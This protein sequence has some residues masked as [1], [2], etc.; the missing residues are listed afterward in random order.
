M[1]PN[2]LILS[3]PGDY[4]LDLEG[5]QPK[6]QNNEKLNWNF[7]Q[8]SN[9]FVQTEL[10]TKV[11]SSSETLQK[12]SSTLSGLGTSCNNSCFCA[13]DKDFDDIGDFNLVM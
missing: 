2:W 9:D 12:D 5:L 3:F 10:L 7:H 8:Y 1:H 11:N 13:L 6:I 4:P